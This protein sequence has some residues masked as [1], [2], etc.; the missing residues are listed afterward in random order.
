MN[1]NSKVLIAAAAGAAAGV[2][3]GL[4]MAPSAGKESREGLLKIAGQVAEGF[5]GQVATYLEKF[6]GIASMLNGLGADSTSTMSVGAD[7]STGVTA[8]GNRG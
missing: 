4:L 3:A 5:N 2:I 1:D 8:D 6:S 7:A